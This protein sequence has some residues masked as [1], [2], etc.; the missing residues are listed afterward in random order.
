MADDTPRIMPKEN[1]SLAVQNVDI[2]IGP[3][4]EALD[5][6]P[7]MFLC[8]CGKSAN[9]PFCD[10]SHRAAGFS[11]ETRDMTA[12]D[13]DFAYP[14]T[15]VEVH[16]NKL[17]CSHAAECGSRLSAVFDPA[18]KPWVQPDAGSAEDIAAVVRAC[19]S[20][21]LRHGAPGAPPRHEVGDAVRITVDRNGPYRVEN[22]ALEAD[23]WG[24]TQSPR[25]YVLCRCGLSKNKPFCDGTHRDEN[26]RDDA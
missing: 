16:F 20:G 15:S 17:L 22:I 5:A 6:Q 7:A 2:F 14:G 13:R 23:N 26:W 11:S 1:G 19:P 8:R 12:R 25:K 24:A 3:D 4:G 18:Q 10:G 9:K 21:A